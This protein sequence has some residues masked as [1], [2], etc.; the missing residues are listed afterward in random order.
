MRGCRGTIFSTRAKDL[1]L[2][3]DLVS[4]V[5]QRP[6]FPE[7]E[8]RAV[9]AAGL[10]VLIVRRNGQL[11]AI[12][13]VCSHAGGPLHEG[14]LEGDTVICPWHAS[15]FRLDG[16]VEGGPATFSQ[17]SLMVRVRNGSVEVKLEAPLH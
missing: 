7:G 16:H 5:T 9:D 14:T 15:R 13:D 12:S 2:S 11:C 3:L 4:D 6:T 10:R 1:S 8:M 17:P